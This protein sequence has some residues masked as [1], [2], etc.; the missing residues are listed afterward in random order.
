MMPALDNQRY[1]LF[2]QALAKGKTS[3]AAY[4]EAGY[5]P[6]RKNASRLTT[7]QVIIDRVLELQE[8]TVE[9]FVI[10]KRWVTDALLENAAKA[11]GRIP[12]KMGNADE[13]RE[14]YVYR[15]DVANRAIQMAGL[16]LG[17]F[18][19]KSEHLIK[20]DF[21]KMTDQELVRELAREAQRLLDFNTIDVT[22]KDKPEEE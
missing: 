5:K 3:D 9:R 4:T 20:N 17:M 18:V 7:N 1:E 11:L 13:A 14:V 8:K 19:Q 22:P 10:S 16:E 2:C 6:N 12:V 15:G 21:E